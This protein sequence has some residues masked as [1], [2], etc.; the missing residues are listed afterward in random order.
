MNNSIHTKKILIAP[1]DWGLGHA[2]RCVVLIQNLLQLGCQVSVAAGG[3]IKALLQ[4]EF[5]EITILQLSGYNIT[6]VKHKRLLPLKILQ[7]LP[8]ILKTI[9]YE[10]KWLC[11]LLVN[12]SFD[13]VISDNR[14]GF[15]S[16]KIPS[17]FIT[18][19]LQVQTN[20]AWLDSLLQQ[21][22]YR[23]INKFNECWVPDLKGKLNVAGKLSHPKKLPETNVKYIG[24]LSRFEKKKTAKIKYKWMAIISGPEP[25]RSI[26]EQKIFESATKIN[27]LF[28]IVRGLPEAEEKLRVPGCEVYNHLSTTDMQTAIEASE[29]IIS[30]CGYTTVMEIIAL[31]KRAVLI[32]TP[33]QTEQEYLA[34]HLMQQNW[35][36]SFQQHED[37]EQNLEKATQFNYQLP[38]INMQAYKEFIAA[39]VEGL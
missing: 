26:F 2:T 16:N 4:K 24:P 32:P 30:R 21:Y 39:F 29:L 8:K 9:S 38:E 22:N 33:G 37:F 13:A 7:Q 17:V 34:K 15:F 27:G 20:I 28:L 31:Q 25:Q 6:Y 18:H 19:Q 3:N 12:Q 1:L 35:C 11:D 10:N 5:P 14:Y 23:Y 36:Y